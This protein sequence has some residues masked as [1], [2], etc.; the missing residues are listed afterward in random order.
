MILLWNYY[1]TLLVTICFC[2]VDRC[3]KYKMGAVSNSFLHFGEL[4]LGFMAIFT[5]LLISMTSWCDISL[6]LG[7]TGVLSWRK[8]WQ[9][10]QIRRTYTGP[11]QWPIEMSTQI[12]EL[13]FGIYFGLNQESMYVILSFL[14][15]LFS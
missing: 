9:E 5:P 15:F 7:C 8:Y 12:Y 6:Y 3:Y 11:K 10:F 4:L 14:L 13:T 2:V 1:G